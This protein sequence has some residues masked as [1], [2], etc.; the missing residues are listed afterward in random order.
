MDRAN[1]IDLEERIVNLNNN[2]NGNVLNWISKLN[3]W[4]Y[5]IDLFDKAEERTGEWFLNAPE[6]ENWI[7]GKNR[8]LW[9]PGDRTVLPL[10]D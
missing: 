6:F 7:E 9:C 2:Q 3:Y 5:Q 10:D 8:I 1:V 4:S